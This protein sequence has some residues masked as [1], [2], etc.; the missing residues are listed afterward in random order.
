M[1]EIKKEGGRCGARIQIENRNRK[2]NQ[3]CN[4]AIS[5]IVKHA[6][7]FSLRCVF[8]RNFNSGHSLS[9]GVRR[10]T[11]ALWKTAQSRWPLWPVCRPLEKKRNGRAWART[12]SSRVT[13]RHI[14][15]YFKKRSSL[16]VVVESMILTTAPS[17]YSIF[18][19]GRLF[20][21]GGVFY[22]FTFV[23]WSILR[24]T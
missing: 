23:A 10:E 5:H 22:G 2:L 8:P 19:C 6:K 1:L 14:G 18:R 16:P 12:A 20:I 13:S 11:K 21:I 7:A 17:F 3:H 24:K 9:Q 4:R 15:G